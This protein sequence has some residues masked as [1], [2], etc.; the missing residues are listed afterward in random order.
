[1]GWVSDIL[2]SCKFDEFP[3]SGFSYVVREQQGVIWNWVFY[4]DQQELKTFI[5]SVESSTAAVVCTLV[6]RCCA[7][8]QQ[9]DGAESVSYCQFKKGP[10]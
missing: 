3:P 2:T 1:M 9:P 8:W 7:S 4:M 6:F 5:S 10:D